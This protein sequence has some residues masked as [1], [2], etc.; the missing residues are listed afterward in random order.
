MTGWRSLLILGA[1]ALALSACGEVR[2]DLG[3]GRSPPDEF[4]VVERAPLSMPPDFSLRPPRPGAPRPQGVDPT[5][6][7]SEALF[8]SPPPSSGNQSSAEKAL[9][10]Q[11]GAAGADPS[12]RETVDHEAAQKVVA[13]PHLVERLMDWNGDAKPGVTVD[14]AAEAARLKKAEENKQPLNQGATPVIEKQDS[15]WLGL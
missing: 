14:P 8:N 13:S 4:A 5:Q 7:A 15:G 10:S 2:E 3:L 1:S 9:L 12:I 6:Q 11:A